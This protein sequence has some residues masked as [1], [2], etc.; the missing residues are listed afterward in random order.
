LSSSAV[1]EGRQEIEAIIRYCRVCRGGLEVADL[2]AYGPRHHQ[3]LL[4]LAAWLAGFKVDNEAFA[5]P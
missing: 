3:R 2:K 5:G 1:T 4:E